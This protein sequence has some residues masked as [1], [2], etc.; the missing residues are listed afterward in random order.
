MEKLYDVKPEIKHMFRQPE[1]RPPAILSQ[2]FTVACIL[3]IFLAFIL[4][5]FMTVE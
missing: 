2:A 4:V 1:P 5:S 3:P